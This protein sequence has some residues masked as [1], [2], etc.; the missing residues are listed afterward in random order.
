MSERTYLLDVHYCDYCDDTNLNA[1]VEL[2][3]RFSVNSGS[4][5]RWIF[6]QLDVPDRARLLE[7][8]CGSRAPLGCKQGADASRLRSL[9]PQLLVG[10]ITAA[11][12]RL[13]A[14]F[15]LDV[16]DAEALPHRSGTFH[17]AI[18]NHTLYHVQ[19]RVPNT[20]SVS[21]NAAPPASAGVTLR[22]LR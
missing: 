17:A 22:R 8:G 16:A 19:N 2:H 5:H 7:V 15:R 10:M 11:R 13:G 18:A 12:S 4:F 6:D 21:S 1:R 14:G 9:S 20:L 3:R